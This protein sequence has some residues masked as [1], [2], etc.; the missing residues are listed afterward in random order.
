M[1][2]ARSPAKRPGYGLLAHVTEFGNRLLIR[3]CGR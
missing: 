1:L 3:K 2:L